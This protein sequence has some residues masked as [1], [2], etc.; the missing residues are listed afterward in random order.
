MGKAIEEAKIAAAVGEIPVGAVVIYKKKAIAHAYNLRESLPCATA[1]AELLAIEKACRALGRWRLTGCT[2]YV[3][4]EPCPMCAGAIV[5]SRLDRV[6][7]G[8]DDPKGGAVRSLFHI[9]DNPSL[10]HRVEVAAGVRAEECAAIMRDFFR[11][12]R[13]KQKAPSAQ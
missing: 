8:C 1:H 12:R 7:Y 2:L 6:V 10:N 11:S 5:N 4:V 13:K 3:T 9:V